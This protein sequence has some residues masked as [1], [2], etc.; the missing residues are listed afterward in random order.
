MPIAAPDS[1]PRVRRPSLRARLLWTA[2][3]ES[4]LPISE[5]RAVMARTYAYLFG[6]GATL[7]MLTLVL[8]GSADRDTLGITLAATCAYL[9]AAG[10]LLGFDRLPLWVFKLSPLLGAALVTV[11]IAFAGVAAIGAYAMFYF[12]VALA[13]CY[14]FGLRL[15]LL[16]IGVCSVCYGGVLLTN[17]MALSG[18]YFAMGPA[19]C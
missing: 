12:W 9:T 15:A 16:H 7:A 17:E 3:S 19:R 1:R 10:F 14:F 8:P 6:L 13:A 18:L 4:G 5:D 11:L 2:V